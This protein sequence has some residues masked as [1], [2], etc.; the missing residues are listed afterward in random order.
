MPEGQREQLPYRQRHFHWPPLAAAKESRFTG[1]FGAYF[2]PV[3]SG[4][5]F[6]CD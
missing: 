5:H 1:F 2:A 3:V 4:V 6:C